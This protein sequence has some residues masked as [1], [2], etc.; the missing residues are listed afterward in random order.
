MS[1][2]VFIIAIVCWVCGVIGGITSERHHKNREL[3]EL[4]K[5]YYDQLDCSIGWKQAEENLVE[6]IHAAKIWRGIASNK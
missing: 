6:C 1:I 3:I 2:R 5:C 4:N